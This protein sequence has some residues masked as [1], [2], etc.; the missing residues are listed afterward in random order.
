MLLLRKIDC[1]SQPVLGVITITSMPIFFGGGMLNGLFFI[2][3][4]Q[5]ISAIFN[6]KI[7]IRT[8]FQ[9]RILIYWKFAIADLLLL[10]L[11]HLLIEITPDNIV[12]YVL[13]AITLIGGI[14][15]AVYYWKI[16]FKLI[17]FI[18]L[19]NELDGLTKSKH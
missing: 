9:K 19:R 16:Y 5:L 13:S 3:C 14:A 1:Y 4:W 12:I 11:S 17:E 10:L 6:T 18:A 15:I 8:G 7:F 2:G